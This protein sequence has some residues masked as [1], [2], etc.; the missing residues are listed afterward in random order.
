MAPTSSAAFLEAVANRRSVYTISNESTVSDEKLKEILTTTLEETPSTFGSFTTRLVLLVKKDHE[1]LWDI[2]A[3]VLKAIVPAEGWEATKT[4][5]DS[6]KAGYGTVLFYEDPENTKALQSK[7]AIYADRFPEWSAHTSAMHQYIVW[8]AL[9]AEGLGA[10][11]QHYNP[12]IDAKVS[13][14]WGIPLE[15]SLIAMLPFGK[16]TAP[17][18]PKPTGMKKPIEERLKVFGA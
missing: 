16:P 1:K 13:A 2:T 4:K 7:F 12:L 6:F 9:E 11:L 14:E 5:I 10:S 3:E 8:T 17:A 15:W 18:G